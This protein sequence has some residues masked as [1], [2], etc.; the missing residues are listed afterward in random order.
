[1]SDVVTKWHIE[2]AVRAAALALM[3][4]KQTVEEVFA[5][6][7]NA[8]ATDTPAEITPRERV[9]AVRQSRREKMFA[10]VMRLEEQG[11]A[12]AAPMLVARKFAAD[13]HDP[14]EVASLARKL[15]RW[16]HRDFRTLSESD[17]FT[18]A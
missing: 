14:V 13:P 7:A 11:R 18:E 2:R 12:R 10:A 1:M 3:A 17:P 15:R 9:A 4:R 6:L 8:V 16:R 5:S